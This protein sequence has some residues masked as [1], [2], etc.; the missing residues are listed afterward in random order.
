MWMEGFWMWMEGFWTFHDLFWMYCQKV[1][2]FLRCEFKPSI[3]T[4]GLRIFTIFQCILTQ[5]AMIYPTK[6][7]EVC[8][9]SGLESVCI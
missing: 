2:T 5:F 4:K 8:I 7:L 6:K 3:K 9:M 1:G